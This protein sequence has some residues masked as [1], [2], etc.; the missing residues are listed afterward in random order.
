MAITTIESTQYARTAGTTTGHNSPLDYS[1]EVGIFAFDLTQSGAG[2]AG[3]TGKLVKLPSGR[4]RIL[5]IEFNHDALAGTI[6]VGHDA[7][8]DTAGATV[9]A[10]ATAFKSASATTAAGT[11]RIFVN[12]VLNSRDGIVVQF[13]TDGPAAIPDGAKVNGVIRAVLM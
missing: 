6:G 1:G 11:K 5:D 12:Q 3:S 13:T 2:D 10:D 8:T 4:M 7:Y 9:A